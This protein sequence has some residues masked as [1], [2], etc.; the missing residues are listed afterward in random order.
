MCAGDV[1]LPYGRPTVPSMLRTAPEN[2]HFDELVTD[3][4]NSARI[5]YALCNLPEPFVCVH[6]SWYIQFN[7]LGKKQKKKVD[8]LFIIVIATVRGAACRR[9]HTVALQCKRHIALWQK[10]G[11]IMNK[12][13]RAARHH[14]RI[15]ANDCAMVL[16]SVC[17]LAPSLFTS[18]LFTLTLPISVF[19]LHWP[20]L[21]FRLT[22]SLFLVTA[23]W[24]IACSDAHAWLPR[25]T[26][27]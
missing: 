20:C 13:S 4:F 25:S 26:Y 27:L 10:S 24:F 23:D 16:A 1:P 2:S 8:A 12:H 19:D 9:L 15:V 21:R 18:T 7:R 5:A 6:Y 14:A 17:W 22:A 3:S 11:I